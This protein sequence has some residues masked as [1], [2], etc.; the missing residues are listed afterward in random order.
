MTKRDILPYRVLIVDDE[1]GESGFGEQAK[2]QLELEEFEVVHALTWDEAK[3][4]LVKYSFD[5]VVV[6]LQLRGPEDGIRVV[7]EIRRKDSR[8]TIV[9]VTGD[10]SYL[11][12]TLRSYGDTFT[13]W[14]V[15]FWSKIGAKLKF[16]EAMREASMLVDPFRRALRLSQAAGLDKATFEI[17]GEEMTVA[18]ILD[19][20]RATAFLNRTMRESLDTLLLELVYKRRSK[21]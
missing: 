18:Q 14:P 4:L 10:D 21:K 11:D 7:E 8:Q 1:K 2:I 20:P 19:L 16:V 17:D 15:H 12:R 9:L 6:D 5:I 13:A 3:A